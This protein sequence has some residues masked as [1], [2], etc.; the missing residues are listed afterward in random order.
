MR[1]MKIFCIV[2]EGAVVSQFPTRNEA[3]QEA[4]KTGG[5]VVDFKGLIEKPINPCPFCGGEILAV[6]AIVSS[7]DVGVECL[8][9][10]AR[11]PLYKHRDNAILGWNTII[12]KCFS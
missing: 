12:T 7:D 1:I 2:K 9:C 10:M 4:E 8:G 5:Q 3:E 6:R 11:G